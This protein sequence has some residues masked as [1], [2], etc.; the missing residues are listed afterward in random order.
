MQPKNEPEF[1]SMLKWMA[2]YDDGPTAIRYPRGV[3]D[4]TP[5][6][7]KVSPI[8]LGKGELIQ[9]GSDVALVG[10]GTFFD[11]AVQ[12]KDLLEEKGFSVS[13]VNP[14]FIK[15]LDTSLLEKVA[16]SS[17]VICTFEDHVLMN[18]FGAA[19]IEHLHDAGI[20][21]K[22]ERI[23]WPDEF[24]E[25]GKPDILH[26]LHHLTPQAAMDKILPHLGTSV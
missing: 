19:C 16:R 25:H 3:I 9:E 8:Q 23:G 10:L 7:E 1:V 12:T 20:P 2:G 11:L 17:K 24:I 4:A 14:R 15:P 26:E 13:L 22:V 6:D 5:L 18:G 21:T